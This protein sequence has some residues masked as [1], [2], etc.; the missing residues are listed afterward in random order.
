MFYQCNDVKAKMNEAG[1][2]NTPFLFG[3]NYEMNESFFVLNPLQQRDILFD[4][5][6]VSNVKIYEGNIPHFHFDSFPEDVET[7][8]KRFDIVM[9]GLRRGNSYL[10]NLTIKTPVRSSLSLYD[11]FM[12]SRAM[13]RFFLPGKFVCFSPERFVKIKNRKIYT[14]PMK[15]TIDADIENAT[16]IILNDYKETAEHNTIVD[17]LRNDLSCVATDVNVRRFRYI[18]SLKTNKGEILQV[19]SEIEGVLPDDYPENLG[20]L[21]FELLPAGSISG[22]PKK[23]TIDMIREAEQESRGFY[24]G[25]AGYFD[26]KELDTC[27][28]IRFIEQRDDELFFR[29]G[30]GITVNSI[31]E[32]EYREAIQK[33]YLPFQPS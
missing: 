32:S 27:V 33:I 1:K 25:V 31:C 30:G 12:Y 2:T 8:R 6:G 26:G 20:S 5:N 18:D 9:S 13:Y 15:G 4:I 29:S 10:A 11:I 14:Y 21:I 23:A 17:L 28:L 16:D 22:A 19:S 3:I 24:T 7:Y